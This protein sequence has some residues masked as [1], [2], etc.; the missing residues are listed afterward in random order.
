[1]VRTWTDYLTNAKLNNSHSNK[2]QTLRFCKLL[3]S[4]V[5]IKLHNFLRLLLLVASPN[6]IKIINIIHCIH[7]QDYVWYIFY[8]EYLLWPRFIDSTVQQ[9]DITLYL[10]QD[11]VS[12]VDILNGPFVLCYTDYFFSQNNFSQQHD[13]RL[14]DKHARIV[15]K[16]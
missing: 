4:L 9:H 13:N 6:Q 14:V 1:M 10:P 12:L 8:M 7:V 5:E 2:E 15:E 3:S 16:K 11:P